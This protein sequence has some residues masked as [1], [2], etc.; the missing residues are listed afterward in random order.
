MFSK[1]ALKIIPIMIIFC[2]VL[3]PSQPQSV[4][5]VPQETALTVTSTTTITQ[6]TTCEPCKTCEPCE[7]STITQTKTS[8]TTTTEI[9]TIASSL[10]L[11]LATNLVTGV[12]VAAAFYFSRRKLP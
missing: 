9:D 10:P 12:A 3:L 6:T 7:P 5:V 4:G 2:I 1:K 8:T 11:I